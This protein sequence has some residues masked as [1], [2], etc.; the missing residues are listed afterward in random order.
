MIQVTILRE[1]QITNQ[2]TF[3]SQAE[4]DAWLASHE[5]MGT[6]GQKATSTVESYESAPAVLNEAGEEISPAVWDFK[7]TDIAGYTVE[8][9]DIS[10]SLAQAKTN[11]ESLA[12]LSATDWYVTRWMETSIPIP[13]EIRS[14]REL[15]RSQI[16]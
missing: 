10:A 7:T 16:K 1:G 13:E 3:P 12:Y 2:A 4:A 6:F 9:E 14:A 15:A 11:Q 8:I 5:G